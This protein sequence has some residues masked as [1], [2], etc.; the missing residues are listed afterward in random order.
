MA[1]FKVWGK[2]TDFIVLMLLMVLAVFMF[3]A[4]SFCILFFWFRSKRAKEKIQSSDGHH[5]DGHPHPAKSDDL[6]KEGVE[7]KS[8][9]IVPQ[10]SNSGAQNARRASQAPIGSSSGHPVSMSRKPSL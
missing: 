8:V 9:T 3:A 10:D 6:K 5:P 7:L 4:I 2:Q 1:S